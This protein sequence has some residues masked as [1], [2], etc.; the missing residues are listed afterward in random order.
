MK[1]LILAGGA[2]SRL[3]PM[4]SA[5]SKQ[6][7]PIYDKPMI[8][9]PLTT[10]MLAGIREILVISTPNDVPL[11][12]R[13]LGSGEQWGIRIEYA[14]QPHPAGL[15]QAF[16]IGS[17]FIGDD[18]SSLILGDN[19]FYG[20]QLEQELEIASNLETG[21]H[22]FAYRVNDPSRYGVVEFD[23]DRRAVSLEEK[24]DNP[25]SNYA[26]TG[27]YC[28]DNQ[29]VDMARSLKPSARGELEITDLN[30]IY[31]EQEQLHVRLLGRGMAW[32]DTGTPESLLSAS[33]FVH[34][35]EARQGFKICCPEEVA[36][37]KG[38]IDESQLGSLIDFYRGCSYAQYLEKLLDGTNIE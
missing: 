34:T 22:V 37:R 21:A 13:L 7:L 14:V 38:Y 17:A 20:H 18:T 5:I 4:T 11:F 30:N 26:V 6:L 12:V 36:F 28:Y 9:Y 1:G 2:G 32:L 33:S 31:L 10:L 23:S 16:T 27:L 15:A 25:R 24:P 29:V 35:M 19:L 8:F 3:Y